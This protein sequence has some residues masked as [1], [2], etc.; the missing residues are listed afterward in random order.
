MS[1]QLA[2]WKVNIGQICNGLESNDEF[3]TL[4]T[5]AAVQICILRWFIEKGPL[6]K[7]WILYEGF[8]RD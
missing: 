1:P 7:V 6:L 5:A 8:N 2:I 4:L 3:Q